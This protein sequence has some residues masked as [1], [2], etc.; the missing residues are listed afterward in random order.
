MKRSTGDLRAIV[1]AMQINTPSRL[2]NRL[3][4]SESHARCV[5]RRGRLLN[6]LC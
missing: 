1:N 5:L 6:S 2:D 4:V 3:L